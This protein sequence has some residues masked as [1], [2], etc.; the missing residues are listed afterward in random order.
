MRTYDFDVA[1]ADWLSAGAQAPAPTD[2]L[3]VVAETTA[4]RRPRP[5]WL[6]NL[7]GHW[8][9]DPIHREPGRPS[10][11]IQTGRTSGARLAF[12]L[13]VALLTLLLAAGAAIVGSRM[14]QPDSLL[15]GGVSIPQGAGAAFTYSALEGQL[16][17]VFTVR[18]DGTDQRAIGPGFD[19]AWS[20]DGSMIA[21]VTG[22]ERQR[23]T[24]LV[25]ADAAG[26][27]TVTDI[28]GCRGDAP[29]WSPDSR[30]IVYSV[31]PDQPDCVATIGTEIQDQFV[32]P[33][34]GSSG[35]HPLLSATLD[36]HGHTPAWSPTGRM[37]AVQSRD[38]D[39]PGLWLADVMDANAPWG[40]VPRRLTKPGTYGP[41]SYLLARW[42]PDGTTLAAGRVADGSAAWETVVM[43]ADDRSET[44]VWPGPEDDGSPEWSP[45]GTRLSI[46]RHDGPG[47]S[48]QPAPY[49]LYLIDPD[50][51]DPQLVLAGVVNGWAGP[52]PFSPDGSRLVGKD[53][54]YNVLVVVTL[55]DPHRLVLIDAPS[56]FSGVSWQPVLNG[57]SP[58]AWPGP[59][60]SSSE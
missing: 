25:V 22:D 29:V 32:I 26:I 1:L 33:A 3:G 2:L 8:I 15:R 39:G 24:A 35:S 38:G 51:G 34:D 58:L 11:L 13:L 54:T 12:G 16:S 6:A 23:L 7:R 18:A 20:P 9:G 41:Q 31:V 53:K 30:F 21:Y 4:R 36:G 5:G 55:D 48:V 27:R 52:L 42:S 17:T 56:A 59:S 50:G 19:P 10:R 40:L 57:R 28:A 37:I 60:P 43:S 49:D 45:D 44:V 14:M 46:V 47:A